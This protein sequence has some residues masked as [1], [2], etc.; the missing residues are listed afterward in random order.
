MSLLQAYKEEWERKET[1]A[2]DVSNDQRRHSTPPLHGRYDQLQNNPISPPQYDDYKTKAKEAYKE[3]WERKE[4]A[5]MDVSND[6][7]RHF[8]PPLHGRYDQLQN[9][10]ISPPQ[11]VFGLSRTI[12]SN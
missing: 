11:E 6:Q 2:M 5:A 3:E 4:T 1:T 8:T 12:W 7:R 10:P 9:N